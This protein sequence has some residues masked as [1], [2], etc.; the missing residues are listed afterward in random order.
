MQN[1]SKQEQL[2]LEHTFTSS[3][4][5]PLLVMNADVTKTYDRIY[6]KPI[7]DASTKESARRTKKK[8]SKGRKHRGK[9]EIQA[10]G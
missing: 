8:L 9:Q 5:D 10:N 7:S 6:K 2:V 4:D 1:F 3:E